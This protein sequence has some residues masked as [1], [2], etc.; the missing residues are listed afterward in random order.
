MARWFWLCALLPACLLVSACRDGRAPKT[1]KVSG[2]VNLDGKPLSEGEIA[3]VGG[4]GTIPDILPVKNGTF[5]GPAKPGKV[6]VEIR[7]FRK[8]KLPDSV[9]EA[10]GEPKENYLPAR[11]NDESKL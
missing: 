7:A 4:P 5:E 3:F 1:V 6:K 9:T 11:F 2:T 8:G 10:S